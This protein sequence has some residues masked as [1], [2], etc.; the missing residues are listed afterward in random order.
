VWPDVERKPLSVSLHYRRSDDADA[1][2]QALE[3]I[4]SS[5]SAAGL[6]PRFG[7]MVLELRPPVDANKGTAVAHLL[8]EQGLRRALYAGDDTTD[9]DA[10][11]AV[12]ALEIGVCVAVVSPEAPPGLREAA[13]L[14]V[15]SPRELVEV[16]RRL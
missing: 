13:D 9:L 14:V 5:A 12:R 16:L 15:S 6:V 7:R 3:E 4:A 10:F 11:A 2:R 8:A 1:A